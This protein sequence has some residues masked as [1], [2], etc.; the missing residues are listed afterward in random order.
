MATTITLVKYNNLDAMKKAHVG[1]T[2]LIDNLHRAIR[3]PN[4][5][6]TMLKGWFPN[7]PITPPSNGDPAWVSLAICKVAG[8]RYTDS[9]R[10]AIAM[11]TVADLLKTLPA[12]VL[13]GNITG[14]VKMQDIERIQFLAQQLESHVNALNAS[15]I[16]PLT[17][18]NLGGTVLRGGAM[19]YNNV[20]YGAIANMIKHNNNMLLAY[21]LSKQ[22]VGGYTKAMHGGRTWKVGPKGD[23]TDSADYQE[24]QSVN[25]SGNSEH[26][27]SIVRTINSQLDALRSKNKTL[28]DNSK[29]KVETAMKKLIEGENAVTGLLE[30]L[31]AMNNYPNDT[32]ADAL[33]NLRDAVKEKTRRELKALAISEGL[34]RALADA[35]GLGVS[36]VSGESVGNQIQ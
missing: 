27:T 28:S 33:A 12:S 6:A 2:A 19:N 26:V 14:G 30:E 1:M 21:G 25:T 4:A 5:G 35:I 18:A 24:L 9:S 10:T 31:S 3:D 20:N 8:L 29:T 34:G 22:S 7:V 17:L 36:Y 23:E 32:P 11:P 13:E 15:N 16:A